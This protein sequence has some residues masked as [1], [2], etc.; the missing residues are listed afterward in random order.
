MRRFVESVSGSVTLHVAGGAWVVVACALL[1]CKLPNRDDKP[2]PHEGPASF[3][4]TETARL[5]TTEG[6]LVHARQLDQRVGS[7]SMR[8][9][10]CHNENGMGSVVVAHEVDGKI[11][12][13]VRRTELAPPTISTAFY[14]DGDDLVLARTNVTDLLEGPAPAP[15]H[16]FYRSGRLLKRT[17][18]AP[19]DTEP[20]TSQAREDLAVARTLLAGIRERSG[21][22][23]LPAGVW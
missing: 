1:A 10:E 13:I 3:Q 21:D 16:R 11:V 8:T 4:G 14:F 12:K 2:P 6:I 5:D 9:S 20:D 15:D 23:R 7:G 18:K 22:I 19:D 17:G